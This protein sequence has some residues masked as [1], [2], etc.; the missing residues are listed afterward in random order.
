MPQAL[1]PVTQHHID[2]AAE[3]LADEFAGHLLAGDDRPLHG[4]VAATCSASAKINV[5]VPV[6]AHRFARERL[7]RSRRRRASLDKDAARGA[8]RLRAQRRPQPDGR[9]A[10]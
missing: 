3:R 9:R 2:Q 4:R 5:F 6:L 8:V 1:D 7:R 10:R